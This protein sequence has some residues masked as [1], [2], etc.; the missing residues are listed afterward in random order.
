[1]IL[2][3]K[4]CSSSRKLPAPYG[5]LIKKYYG[6]GT[7]G[8]SCYGDDAKLWDKVHKNYTDWGRTI[9]CFKKELKEAKSIFF[10]EILSSHG[11][12]EEDFN[13]WDKLRGMPCKILKIDHKDSQSYVDMK[14]VS[15]INID[16]EGIS[17]RS[18]LKNHNANFDFGAK[19]FFDDIQVKPIHV[20]DVWERL[21]L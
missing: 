18:N 21:K 1:M 13:I 9:D 3:A 7:E 15:W 17:L 14:R 2:E 12:S 6:F 16:K 10:S 5:D 19:L 8:P 11:A 20:L 4:F